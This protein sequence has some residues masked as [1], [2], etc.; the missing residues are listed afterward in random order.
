ML[1]RPDA[2]A[3]FAGH[4]GLLWALRFDAEGRAT[5]LEAD[6]PALTSSDGGSWRWLH[7]NQSDART[8]QTLA[9]LPLDEAA[10][11]NLLSHDTH[12]ILQLDPQGAHGVWVDWEHQRASEPV[13]R[14]PGHHDGLG[15][16]HFAASPHLIVT[17]RRQPLRSVESVRRRLIGGEHM[18]N[19]LAV[20]ET[21]SD[22]F[23][24]AT[25]RAIDQ[26]A[27]ALD[28]IED[29]VLA[30]AIGDER[31]DLASLRHQSVRLHRPLTAMRRVLKQFEQRRTADAESERESE[32]QT[33]A[34][35]SR[36]GQ[37]FDDLDGDVATV[38]ERARL[39]QDEVAA[40]LA[41]RTNR[42]LYVLSMITALLLPPS[43]VVGVF[44]MNL[45]GLPLAD[46]RAGAWTAILLGGLS[47]LGV[48]LLLRRLGMA[49]ST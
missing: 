4:P 18:D 2:A 33:R 47:S 26:L 32:A 12:V 44:G 27:E 15:W 10:R 3:L 22:H 24:D 17:A 38:Q 42:H 25:E 7:F 46:H 20:L 6:D 37:R 23:A 9:S 36:L 16:L 1:V 5:P 35:A 28:R 49:R 21:I 48:Y 34:M 29:R 31:R 11:E 41:E 13:T 39:L 14:T 43:L 45:H 40:K 30:D 8:A 19:P